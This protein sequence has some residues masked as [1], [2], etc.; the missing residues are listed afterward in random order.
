MREY[1]KM[2]KLLYKDTRNYVPIDVIKGIDHLTGL[3]VMADDEAPKDYEVMPKCKN[4]INFRTDGEQMGICE[5]SLNEPKF[6]AYPD[7]VAVTCEMYSRC[8]K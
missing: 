5:C 3:I 2:E 4:C 8:R 6:F 7:M 1:K